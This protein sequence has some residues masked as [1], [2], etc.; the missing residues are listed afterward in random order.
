M[1]KVRLIVTETF[2]SETEAARKENL[3]RTVD[4][5]IRLILQNSGPVPDEEAEVGE[6]QE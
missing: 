6:E 5:Y 1:D 3:Q 2:R 4:Q